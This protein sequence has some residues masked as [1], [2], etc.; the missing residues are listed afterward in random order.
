MRRTVVTFSEVADTKSISAF[1]RLEL[2]ASVFRDITGSTVSNTESIR[3]FEAD[4]W[5]A[6]DWLAF[7]YVRSASTILASCGAL[8]A[9]TEGRAGFD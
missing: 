9:D 2:R 8:W 1:V 7:S 4:M 5:W 3:A 6:C